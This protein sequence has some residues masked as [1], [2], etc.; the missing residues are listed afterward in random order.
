MIAI[1]TIIIIVLGVILSIYVLVANIDSQR[2]IVTMIF[3]GVW[4]IIWAVLLYLLWRESSYAASWWLLLI[5]I[6]IMLVY[7]MVIVIFDL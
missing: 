2:K 4:V 1:P 3:Y 5:A 6:T 7:F